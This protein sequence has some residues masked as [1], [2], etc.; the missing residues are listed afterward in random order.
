MPPPLKGMGGVGGL[1]GNGEVGLS[2]PAAASDRGGMDIAAVA[3]SVK[4]AEIGNQVAVAVARK[5]L[6]AQEQQGQAAIKLLESA[7]EI[8]SGPNAFGGSVDVNG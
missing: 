2:A 5:A 7:R 8:Q 6:D 3:T 1:G 4:Q